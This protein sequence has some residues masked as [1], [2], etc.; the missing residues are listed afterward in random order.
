M[1]DFLCSL[2]YEGRVDYSQ[3]RS[4]LWAGKF[5]RQPEEPMPEFA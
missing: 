5:T 2:G 1:Q 4:M 3:S